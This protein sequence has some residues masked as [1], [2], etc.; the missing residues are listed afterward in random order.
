MK[1]YLVIDGDYGVI[2]CFTNKNIAE[3]W[4][5]KSNFRYSPII[6]E[7]DL[8]LSSENSDITSIPK[9]Y[10]WKSYYEKEK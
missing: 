3:I 1:I 4:V 8:Y 2:Q 5:S 7:I 9:L 10:N 6:Q